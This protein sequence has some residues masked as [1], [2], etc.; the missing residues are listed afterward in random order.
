MSSHLKSQISVARGRIQSS[1]YR[2]KRCKPGSPAEA[3]HKA[4]IAR[5]REFIR[6]AQRAMRAE[7]D[8]RRYKIAFG[9]AFDDAE[10]LRATSGH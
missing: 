6:T 1:T 10:F 9:A 4:L 3:M 7:A 2:L 8:A 5:E